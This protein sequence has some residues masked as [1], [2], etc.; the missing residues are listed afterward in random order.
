MPVSTHICCLANLPIDHA[1]LKFGVS[2]STGSQPHFGTSSNDPGCT[3]CITLKPFSRNSETFAVSL[4]RLYVGAVVLTDID[5]GLQ[6][7]QRA[8]RFERLPITGD[9]I[10][11][12]RLSACTWRLRRETNGQLLRENASPL[13]AEF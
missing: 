3:R 13:A 5:T 6:H 2:E 9:Y 8:T 10:Q 1:S 11:N 7:V 12:T 4:H